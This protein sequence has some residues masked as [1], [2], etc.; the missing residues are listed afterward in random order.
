MDWPADPQITA[1]VRAV[2][3]DPKKRELLSLF[4]ETESQTGEEQATH[5]Y[6]HETRARHRI[7]LLDPESVPQLVEQLP[8]NWSIVTMCISE[9]KDRLMITRRQP[10]QQSL[11]LCVPLKRA[12]RADSEEISGGLSFESAKTEMEDIVQSSSQNGKRAIQV[13]SQSKSVRSEWWAERSA[14][15]ERLKVLLENIEFCWL[16]AFKV[17][18]LDSIRASLLTLP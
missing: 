18:S 10:G 7:Q 16:G 5:H 11:L 4:Q 2:S 1:S 9:A 17:G 15:D 6:W 3:R 14:L 12:S 13:A 8:Q